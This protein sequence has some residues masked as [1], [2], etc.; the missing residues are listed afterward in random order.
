MPQQSQ[1]VYTDRTLVTEDQIQKLMDERKRIPDVPFN[2]AHEW[3]TIS[4]SDFVLTRENAAGEE[5]FM[6][7]FRAEE[8]F[9]NTWFVPG[10]RWNCGEHPLDACLRHLKRELGVTDVKP[11]FVDFLSVWNPWSEARGIWH[12]VWHLYR[13]PVGLDQVITK[14]TEASKTEWFTHVDES[15]PDPVRE[16]LHMLGFKVRM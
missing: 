13:V 15:W 10:G 12:S 8:P 11:E 1:P 14:N 2:V 5:E 16:A 4:T 7:V 9:G 6:L 3:V